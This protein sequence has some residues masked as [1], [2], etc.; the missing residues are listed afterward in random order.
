[1][2]TKIERRTAS[3]GNGGDLSGISYNDS[4]VTPG[5][6]F[7]YD[8]LGRRLTAVRGS[9]TTTF[10]DTDASLPLGESHAGG[11]LGGWVETNRLNHGLQRSLGGIV[12]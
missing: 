4:G 6:T 9:T 12:P 5:V 2:P 10:D 8:R 11:T 3:Y 7:T 1:M